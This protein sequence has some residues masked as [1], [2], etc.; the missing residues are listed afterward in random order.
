M[1]ASLLFPKDLPSVGEVQE[2]PPLAGLTQEQLCDR[3]PGLSFKNASRNAKA[4]GQ[5]TEQYLHEKSRGWLK[6]G[7]RWYPPQSL[8]P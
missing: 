6:R 5:S 7:K 3:I 8:S 4:A 1:T 2:L